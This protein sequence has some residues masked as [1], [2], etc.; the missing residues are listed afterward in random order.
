MKA[1]RDF[2]LPRAIRVIELAV[3]IKLF[4]GCRVRVIGWILGI[5]FVTDMIRTKYQWS[6]VILFLLFSKTSL[7]FHIR[8]TFLHVESLKM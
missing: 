6:R 8:L 4:S 3:R 7:I 2:S 1:K 5:I